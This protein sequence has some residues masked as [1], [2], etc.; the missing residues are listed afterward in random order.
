[1]PFRRHCSARGAGWLASRAAA[2]CGLALPD[3]HER[4]PPTDR[5]PTAPNPFAGPRSTAEPDQR[6]RRAGER[7]GVA[8]AVAGRRLPGQFRRHERRG[9]P[10]SAI[11][12]ARARRVRV[13]AALQHLPGTQRAVLLLREV[14]EFSAAETAAILDTSPPSVNSALQRARKAI[15]DRVP[16]T[17]QQAELAALG[18]AGQRELVDAFVAAWE[19]ADV[20]G[21]VALLTEDA[22]HHAAAASRFDG[23][24]PSHGSSQ[25]G[26]RDA[27]A[28]GAAATNGQAVSPATSADLASRDSRSARSTC[29]PPTDV[30]AISGFLDPAVHRAFGVPSELP[31]E[32]TRA[33]R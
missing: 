26:S 17:S 10:G 11:P 28:T 3:R 20:D 25:R 13:I 24:T 14:L 33:D 6:P 32:G 19:S 31:G 4:L 30:R 1:M 15:R 23:A 5:P 21:L 2:R 22:V 27:M 29:E 12:A 18:A 7:S 8:R 9:G 16:E